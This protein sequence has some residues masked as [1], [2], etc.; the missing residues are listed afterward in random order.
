MGFDSED[1]MNDM[2]H[3]H[4]GGQIGIRP[5]DQW[6]PLQMS[7][8]MGDVSGL[9]LRKVGQKKKKKNKGGPEFLDKRNKD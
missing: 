2:I 9:D 5:R 1:M 3:V 8:Q 4:F 7:H 6:E